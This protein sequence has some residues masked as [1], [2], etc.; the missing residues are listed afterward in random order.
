[1]CDVEMR[2]VVFEIARC[3]L[4]CD[5]VR[6]ALWHAVKSGFWARPSISP[7]VLCSFSATRSDIWP[8]I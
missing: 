3:G 7:S 2:G 4:Q 1:M 8:C 5:A 6:K